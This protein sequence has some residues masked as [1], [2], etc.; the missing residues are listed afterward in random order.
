MVFDYVIHINN[1]RL[2]EERKVKSKENSCDQIFLMVLNGE[3]KTSCLSL[4]N[5]SQ[6]FTY[7]SRTLHN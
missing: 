6:I 3:L 2:K 1:I 4:W 7:T 5:S